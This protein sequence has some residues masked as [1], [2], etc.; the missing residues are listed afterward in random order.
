MKIESYNAIEWV[1]LSDL[2]S[3]D[4]SGWMSVFWSET[5]GVCKKNT[6]IFNFYNNKYSLRKSYT[7]GIARELV[8]NENFLFL[9]ELSL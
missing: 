9:V 3:Y 4:P 5:I 6:N 2:D 7:S 1:P 8:N